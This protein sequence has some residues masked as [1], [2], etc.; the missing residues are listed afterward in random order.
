MVFIDDILVYSKIKIEH[1]EHLRL[2]LQILTEKKLYVKLS[3][4]EFWMK[5]V[6]FLEH[7][8]SQGGIF[9]DPSKVKVV[10]NWEQPTTITKVR[11]FLG[12]GR[13][14]QQFI[15]NF[16]QIALPL[17]ELTR[18]DVPFV[19]TSKCKRS[20]Q[21]LKEKLTIAP[22]LILPDRCGPFEVYCDASKKGLGCVLMQNKNVVA[23][24]SR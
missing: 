10:L 17:T 1:A 22:V 14:Y 11:S 13:Y 12:L 7:I 5:E 2:V 3:K 6:K 19:W 16:S 8:V 18:K 24:A 20:C 15:K 4:C 21:E 23:Y 9:I